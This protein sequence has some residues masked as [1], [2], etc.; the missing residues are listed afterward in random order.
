MRYLD[1]NFFGT[2]FPRVKGERLKGAVGGRGS[3]GIE[4]CHFGLLLIVNRLCFLCEVGSSFVERVSSF[5]LCSHESIGQSNYFF[6]FFIEGKMPGIQDVNL[7]TRYIPLVSLRAGE[8]ERRAVFS[9]KN[10][11]GRLTLPQPFLPGR[12][13]FHI[14]LLI[15]KQIHLDLDFSLPWLI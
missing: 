12:T 8:G 14:R 10:E 1:L 9:P 13:G 11:Q 5:E 2:D 7:G 4:I 6:G 15:K 3:V